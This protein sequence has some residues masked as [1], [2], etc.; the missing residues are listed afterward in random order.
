MEES[1]QP[2]KQIEPEDGSELIPADIAPD[3]RL[4][5]VSNRRRAPKYQIEALAKM[6]ARGVR[7]EGMVEVTGLPLD[8]ILRIT[9]P[10]AH[11]GFENLLEGFRE[12]NQRLAVDHHYEMIERLPQVYKAIDTGL[13]SEDDRLKVETGF[14]VIRELIPAPGSNGN[15]KDST[16]PALQVIFNSPQLQAQVGDTIN[17]L[18][19][20]MVGVKEAI[21]KQIPNQHVYR[22]EE[23]LPSPVSKLAVT[24]G[25]ALPIPEDD[26]S[27]LDLEIIDPPNAS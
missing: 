22:G 25:E 3:D 19:V 26:L 14:K 13:S 8:Y 17:N 1:V 5:E 2:D 23:A 21:A 18:G 12:Q 20:M 11:Q 7:P 10:G 6:A 16:D 15:G 24:D 9:K 27:T 4:P